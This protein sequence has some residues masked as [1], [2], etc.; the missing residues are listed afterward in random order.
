NYKGRA[1]NFTLRALQIILYIMNRRISALLL[2]VL[3]NFAFARTKGNIFKFG[4]NSSVVIENSNVYPVLGVT[5]GVYPSRFFFI[6]G[7][8]EYIFRSEY[9]EVNLPLTVNFT[10]PTR[11]FSPY[12]GLGIVYHSYIYPEDYDY[13]FGGRLKLGSKVIDSKGSSGSIEL[14]Y[15]LPD[16]K[17][18]KGRWYFTARFD[19]SL[20]VRF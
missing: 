20:E 2:I 4:I 18:S 8:G 13:S 5:G 11:Y 6:E 16:F 10:Y 17:G 9:K 14:S 12:A 15:D 1:K 7:S 19:Q 3:V